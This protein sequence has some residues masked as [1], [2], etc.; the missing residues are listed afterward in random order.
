MQSNSWLSRHRYRR[1]PLQVIPDRSPDQRRD[2]GDWDTGIGKGVGFE[3]ILGGERARLAIA[4]AH[5]KPSPGDVDIRWDSALPVRVAE[6]KTGQK[7]TTLHTEWYAITVYDVPLPESH[8]GAEKLKG[9]RVSP[10]REQEGL[11]AGARRGGEKRRRNRDC[12]V[13]F[14]PVGGDHEG[15]QDSDFRRAV[16]PAFCVAVLLSA[17]DGDARPDGTVAGTA[18]GGWQPPRRMASCPTRR[19]VL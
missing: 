14:Q 6:E 18:R 15:R 13:P 3:A 17:P 4:R 19:H 9:Q 8:W 12:H 7:P 2:S 1:V 5:D 16:R 10:P 11:Q